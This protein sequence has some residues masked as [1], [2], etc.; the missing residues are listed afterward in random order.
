MKN[1][2]LV[3]MVI[4]IALS[5]FS[6]HAEDGWRE[7][8]MEVKVYLNNTRDAQK[9]HD[10]NLNGDVYSNVYP[11]GFGIMYLTPDELD[12][13]EDLNLSYQVVIKNLNEHYKDFWDQ[14]AYR[15]A[16]EII[17]DMNDL[18]STYPDICKKTVYGSSVNNRELSALKISDNVSTDENEGEVIFD[19]GIHGNEL[20]GPENM[21]L[22]AEELCSEYGNNA[23]ITDLIDNQEI[24]IY[25]TVNPDGRESVSRYNAN[26]IDLNR[27]YG[28]MTTMTNE[29]FSEPETKAIRNCLLENQ[30]SIQIS[31][32][33]G[34][35]YILYPW[36]LYSSQTPDKPHHQ[37]IC[38]T[39]SETSGYQDLDVMQSYASYYTTGETLDYAYGALGI[40]SMTEEIS[41]DKQPSDI[42]GFYNKNVDA[43]LA[44]IEYAGY[45]LKGTITDA[46]TRAPVGAIVIVDNCYPIY[47]DPEV[48]DYHKFVKSGTYS[49]QVNANGY[50]PKTVANISVQDQ[51][52]TVTDIQIEPE[53][54]GTS[55]W[56]YKVA[57]VEEGT[58]ITPDVL[59]SNDN[60]SF[61]LKNGREMVI[62]MQ[63]AIENIDG[64][65]FKVHSSNTSSY[66]FY[67]GEEVDGPWESLGTGSGTKEFDLD[68]SGLDN[69]RYVKI[70]GG[71]AIDAIEAMWDIPVSVV[72]NGSDL[73]QY[74][75]LDINSLNKNI[76]FNIKANKPYQLSVYDIQGKLHLETNRSLNRNKL[77]W[78]PSST[79]MYFAHL[80]SGKEVVVK[81]FSVV[82]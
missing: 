37:L 24:W 81:R 35:E 47:S 4:L 5:T 36:G 57:F 10:L 50:K 11:T 65:D 7:G 29:G 59:Y 22:F 42:M 26:G 14:R 61:T 39:Y 32:H 67:A 25:C 56:G 55:T 13:I 27:N 21:I 69:A 62:D 9:L 31:Y 70:S 80:E 49:I 18:V 71:C 33:S 53:E 41:Y 2:F 20:G 66:T 63:F 19:G 51:S 44:M 79:G 30:F 17:Q 45:G 43:M 46:V 1:I 60:N 3:S 48:G 38:N 15:S 28:Y 76:I 68:G 73:K 75:Q 72:S 52:S 64:N 58:G 77:T 74:L 6:L 40:S 54:P 12:K 16:A 78:Q 8:E 34:I 23:T 82:N